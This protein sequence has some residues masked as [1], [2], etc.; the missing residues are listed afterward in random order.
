MLAK[1][2][3]LFWAG[4]CGEEDTMDTIRRYYTQRNYL[5]DT[6]TAV[7]GSCA[8]SNTAPKAVTA[9]RL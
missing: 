1:V 5:M 6:H 9:G 2:R 8:G 7:A 4:S 3:K